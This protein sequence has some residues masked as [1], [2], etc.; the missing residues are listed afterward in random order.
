[1][2]CIFCHI[3]IAGLAFIG[4]LCEPGDSVS[5]VEE[6]GGFQS[7]GTAAHELGHRYSRITLIVI[8]NSV[9]LIKCKNNITN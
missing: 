7:I 2:C 9:S 8:Y 4:T 6:Q 5:I 1:L 3:H